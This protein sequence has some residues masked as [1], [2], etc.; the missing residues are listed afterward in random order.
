MCKTS[1]TSGDKVS[2]SLPPWCIW[3]RLVAMISI[4]KGLIGAAPIGNSRRALYRASPLTPL[5]RL[6]HCEAMTQ[7]SLYRSPALACV[8]ALEEPQ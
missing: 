7:S 3:D 8:Q 2:L 5:L 6:L 1:L 4:D